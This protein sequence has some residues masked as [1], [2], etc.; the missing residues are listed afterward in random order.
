MLLMPLSSL[1]YLFSIFIVLSYGPIVG[2]RLT[3]I[4]QTYCP[5]ILTVNL[6]REDWWKLEEKS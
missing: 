6:A 3:T 5:T 4:A 2:K 1:G